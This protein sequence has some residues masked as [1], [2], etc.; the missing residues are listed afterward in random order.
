MDKNCG[1]VHL[2]ECGDSRIMM[3]IVHG[4]VRSLLPVPTMLHQR[5]LL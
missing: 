3:V 5:I 1:K 2:S 4:L